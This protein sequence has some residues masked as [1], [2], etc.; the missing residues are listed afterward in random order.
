MSAIKESVRDYYT[1]LQS[2]KDLKTSACCTLPAAH[3]IDA[4]RRVPQE[5]TDKF[6]GCGNP[7]PNGIKGLTVLD[8][9][10]G[11]GRDCYIAS[12][13]VGPKGVVI[14]LDM[15]DSQLEVANKHVRSYCN[16]LGY[17]RPNMK[18][19]KGYIEQV[20][21]VVSKESVDLIISNCVINLS[22]D[23]PA[24]LKQCYDAL[25]YG[26][27]LHFSDVYSDRRVPEK[28]RND[29]VLVGECLGGA[30]YINDFQRLC[31]EIGFHCPRLLTSKPIEVNNEELQEKVGNIKFYSISYRLFKLKDLEPTEEDYGQIAV[32]KGTI[33]GCAHGVELDEEHVFETARATA[34]SGN[35]AAILQKSW[36][37]K[38]FEVIGGRYIHFGEFGRPVTIIP[39]TSVSIAKVT[40]KEDKKDDCC[41]SSKPSKG[42]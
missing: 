24:V 33:P 39:P 6:Y 34:V 38:Y 5:I 20:R 13:L 23:K 9:G 27:E 11:T 3:I 14:G 10:C 40:T 8:L 2:S 4:L 32:Y 37:G 29:D 1:K 42:G 31:S 12:Q 28:V 19:V 22:P 17:S 35:T 25:K 41:G 15:T 36:L 18:F 16:E 21:A 30:M 26:G 7:I